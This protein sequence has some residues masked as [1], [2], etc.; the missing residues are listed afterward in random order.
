MKKLL[1]SLFIFLLMAG[2]AMA[3]DRTIT[4]TVTGKEDGLPLPGVSVKIRGAGG[5]TTAADGKYSIRAKTGAVVEF[6]YIGFAS[7]V[8]TVGS[9]NVL[10]VTLSNDSKTLSDVVVTGYTTQSKKDVTGSIASVSGEKLKN[11]PVQS[12]EQALAGKAAGVNIIQPNGVLN[13]PPVF[14]VRGF[15]SISLSSYPLIIVDGIPV[16]TGDQSAN[17]AAGNALGDINPADIESID[18][19]KDAASS[20]I[21]GS[22]AANGVVVI[23][24]KKGKQGTTK[25]NYEG[26]VGSTKAQNVTP[27]LNAAEYVLIK[28]EARTNIGLAPAFFLQTRS[29]GSQVETNWYDYA[30]RTATAQNHALN[31]SGAN[32]K[33]SYYVSVGYSNQEGFIVGN[34]FE[35][36]NGRVNLDHKLFK[37]VTIGTNFSYS[38]TL[39]RAP[40][41]GSLPGQAFS[42]VGLGRLAI[43]LPPNVSAYNEDG[44]YNMNASGAIGL[45]ANTI[46][47]NF[48]NAAVLVNED[49]NTS[50]SDR[51]IANAYAS[52][53]L[54]K[55][56][57]FK[58][59]YGLDNLKIDNN[60]FV[61]RLQGDGFAYNGGATSNFVKNSRWNWSNTL[62]Y[63]GVFGDHTVGAFVGAEDQYTKSNGYGATRQGVIDPFIEVFQG[64]FGTITPA[65]LVQGDNAFRSYFGSVNYDYK[66]KYYITG[67]FRRDGY[68]GLSAGNKYG[69]FGGA[70]AGWA[71]SEE[72]FYKESGISKV[73]TRI[74]FHG[75]YGEVGNIN[76]GNYPALFLYNPGLYGSASALSFS[77]AGNPDLKWETSKKADI[78][79]NLEFLGG[80]FS[81][82]VDYYHN[83]IDNLV[84][85]A[86]QSPSKG[87]P[88]NTIT[89]N[90]G[91]MYNKGFE[92]TVNSK[93]IEKDDFSWTTSLTFSTLKN[94]VTALGNNN[95]DVFGVTSLETANITRV[96]YPIGSIYTVPTAGVDPATGERIFINRFGQKLRF[97]FARATAARYQYL[98]GA[99]AG[100]NAPAIDAALDATITGQAIP[101]WFGG[102]DNNFR[103]KAFD[104]TL[105]LT[106]SGGNKIYYGSLA[107]LRDQRFW[108]N[109]VG[110]LNRWTTPGQITDIPRVVYGDNTSN[111]SAF[112]QS[113]NVFSGNF[114]K[115]RNLAL[116]YT[117]PKAM[118]GKYGLSNVRL[119]AQS[120][121]LLIISNYP[122]PDPEV[123]VNGNSTGSGNSG[124]L[125]PGVDRNSVPSGRTFTFGINVG[126]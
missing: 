81:L 109:E 119:Y 121:N 50:E 62:A 90:V 93:N 3:Q 115:V 68:S 103:Y 57:T 61:N 10:N 107:G 1:Q 51:I 22:R 48:P 35:R 11:L 17:S 45:G 72:N 85:N 66:K 99:N 69:N 74:K 97:S 123:S 100:Q 94:E 25:I 28:N 16:F 9:S 53:Q 80:R 4:G 105:G 75:S 49:R 98:E 21:Y 64:S 70:S 95:A 37:N 41:T 101:K 36:K 110:L 65:G 43:V 12:F 82:D 24:T 38:N 47:S 44:S 114:L 59:T 40:N 58:T 6:S 23:T 71:L 19:L 34:S 106:F 79:V 125:A 118:L 2:S 46:A 96:G 111:G 87:I 32:D 113:Q 5:T 7:Q 117:L 83:N 18:I 77:Q 8:K 112:A 92:F 60:S 108:N 13:N 104:L 31:F 29:D 26:W 102:L 89:T 120:S 67:S 55:G 86:P 27:L 42:T 122:G 52:I 76:I 91:K 33:T 116:G 14:R 78:G 63:N 30:Y 54:V 73:L 84:Q 56:L 124:N 88:G 39:N 126:F 15:N 20:A